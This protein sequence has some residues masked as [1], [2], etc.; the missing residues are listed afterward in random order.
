MQKTASKR[1]RIFSG[2]L[3]AVTFALITLL[4][5]YDF[6]LP[7]RITYRAGDEIP[8]Y[9]GLTYDTD[10]AVYASSTTT[11]IPLKT[12]IKT[13]KLFGLF[14]LKDVEVAAYGDLRLCPGGI[15]FGVKLY[16]EGILVVGF[17]DVD[18]ENGAV[19]PA[20]DA[21]LRPKDI[22]LSLDGKPVGSVDELTAGIANGNGKPIAV[23]YT[24]GAETYTA[25]ITPVRSCADGKYKT[26]MWVR[27]SGAGIGTVTFIDPTTG[28]FGGL[29]HGICDA[30]TGELLP[31]QRGTVMDVTINGV[32]PGTA[33][34][35]GELCGSFRSE[36]TGALI[37]N[38]DC[39][40]YGV[41]S[42]I[43]ETLPEE[44]MPIAL[45]SEIHAGEAYIWC[46]LDES[47]PARYSVAISA[48]NKT[49][50]GSKS[51]VIEVTDPALIEKTGGIVQGM[52]GSP[53]IQDG[54]LVGA[55][56]HVLI[57][58]P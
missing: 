29:G 44:A 38:T 6:I 3:L 8:A 15:P 4:G 1:L 35:P 17:D 56:T 49:S 20:Y 9:I 51:F 58:D 47:G 27:D 42:A 31:M 34:E 46:T 41:F 22:I 26:G 39:G 13:L 50:S 48:I 14:P 11:D 32:I 5:I 21:G 23:T 36:K 33:G 30:D 53:V 54:K 16:T 2:I 12:E 37:K 25:N 10:D 18:S 7:D 19:N 28:S 43:P 55:V 40:V 45:K 52:S 24:R 57:N